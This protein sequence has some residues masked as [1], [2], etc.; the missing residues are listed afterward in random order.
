I[1]RY[2]L[3]ILCSSRKPDQCNVIRCCQERHVAEAEIIELVAARSRSGDISRYAI[4]E[5]VSFVDA[6]ERTSVGKINKKKLRGLHDPVLG[7]GGR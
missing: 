2:W 6:I 1:E 7:T 5:R 4:P 3:Y